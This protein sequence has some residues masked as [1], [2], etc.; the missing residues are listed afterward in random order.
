MKRLKLVASGSRASDTM[1]PGNYVIRC[2]DARIQERGNKTQVVLTFQI[3]EKAWND[4][5]VLTQWYGLKTTEGE[6]SPHTKYGKACEIA[7]GRALE[8]GY[9]LDPETVFVGK[10]FEAEI[11][12]SSTDSDGVSDEGNRVEKKNDR[13][14]LRVHS[15]LRLVS[16][17]E[18]GAIIH[19]H[20]NGVI[21]PHKR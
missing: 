1:T 12:Y 9:D 6:I 5:V 7:L 18:A 2:R 17:D 3:L 10:I 11:G 13:D 8:A 20:S 16:Q 19:M 14:F 15:L 21:W 4:G